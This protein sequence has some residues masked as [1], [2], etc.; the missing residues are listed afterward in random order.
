MFFHDLPIAS[1]S[2]PGCASR[3][4]HRPHHPRRRIAMM[5]GWVTGDLHGLGVSALCTS[6]FVVYLATHCTVPCL[7]L[8]Q[9]AACR[10]ACLPVVL[11]CSCSCRL[12]LCGPRNRTGHPPNAEFNGLFALLAIRFSQSRRRVLSEEPRSLTTATDKGTDRPPSISS[13]LAT[14]PPLRL[15]TIH[16]RRRA[17]IRVIRLFQPV[18]LSL[19]CL[20]PSASKQATKQEALS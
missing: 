10:P 18:D 2:P 14:A 5:I 1:R 3:R 15:R 12:F 19:P 9:K 16:R 17:R 4:A 6:K 13:R 7:H 11:S 8:F 20:Q